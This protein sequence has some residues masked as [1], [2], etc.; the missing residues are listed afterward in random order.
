[1]DSM[2]AVALKCELT[3]KTVALKCELT[4]KTVGQRFSHEMAYQ[5]FPLNGSIPIWSA[6]DLN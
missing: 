2:E 4:V 1:M 5:V 6:S 3:V